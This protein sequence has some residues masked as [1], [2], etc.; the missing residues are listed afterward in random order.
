[1]LYV[2]YKSD[3]RIRSRDPVFYARVDSCGGCVSVNGL[4]L[5]ST[6]V[7]AKSCLML[8][9]TVLYPWHAHR[10]GAVPQPAL[11]Y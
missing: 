11:D 2:I 8:R 1:M 5:H 3:K 9:G 10:L 4:M 6:R 7:R